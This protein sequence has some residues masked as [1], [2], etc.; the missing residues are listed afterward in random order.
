MKTGNLPGWGR[1]RAPGRGR[2]RA[3]GRGLGDD[4]GRMC[5]DAGTRVSSVLFD[6]TVV[7]QMRARLRRRLRR[8]IFRVK[9]SHRLGWSLRE[10]DDRRAIERRS[11][12]TSD[13]RVD[14][15]NSRRSVDRG[16]DSRLIRF[17]SLWRRRASLHRHRTHRQRLA[18]DMLRSGRSNSKLGF[19]QLRAT[20]GER[21]TGTIESDRTGQSPRSCG[22]GET[23]ARHRLVAA[24]RRFFSGTTAVH[25]RVHAALVRLLRVHPLYA[26]H[27]ARD[28]I[29]QV[30]AR[31]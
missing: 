16:R 2:A 22:G 24:A 27:R 30:S 11:A 29:L 5:W 7:L 13:E 10:R 18:S 9:A 17:R 6:V 1:A 3:P 26:V 20:K 25:D 15:G 12:S 21:G 4:V 19:A 31:Q 14:R 23:L 28:A 8:C